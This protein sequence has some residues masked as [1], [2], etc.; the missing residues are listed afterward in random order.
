MG[1]GKRRGSVA[2]SC[3]KKTTGLLLLSWEAVFLYV[4]Y[5]SHIKKNEDENR[6]QPRIVSPA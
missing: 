2:P 1:G 5:F 4:E 6:E 3:K